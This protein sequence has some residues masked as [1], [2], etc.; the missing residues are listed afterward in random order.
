MNAELPPSAARISRRSALAWTVLLI[1]PNLLLFAW[2]FR[3]TSLW[4]YIR[5]IYSCSD[6]TPF[7]FKL[8]IAFLALGG[9]C[10]LVREK[11]AA[12]FSKIVRIVCS[13]HG[14]AIFIAAFLLLLTAALGTG[15]P[16]SL[17]R[18][19]C[20]AAVLFCA[21]GIGS[22]I[23]ASKLVCL[24]TKAFDSPL[25]RLVLSSALGLGV[26][27]L[28]VFA[29]GS[30]GLMTS[31]F[32][33]LAIAGLC[34]WNFKR[35]RTM[36]GDFS[37]AAKKRLGETNRFALAI[38]IFAALFLIAHLP[39]IWNLPREYDTL[40]YHLAAP[41]EY[42]STGSVHFLSENIYA[43]M[44]E[45][46]EMLYLLPML[47]A[48]GKFD[49]LP[50]AHTILFAAWLLAMGGVYALA[51]RLER[52]LATPSERADSIA[53]LG[54]ALLFT[55]VPMGSQL[56]ADF[57]VEPF[58]ALFHVCAL[59]CACVFLS[60]FKIAQLFKA[61]AINSAN[62]W[63]LCVGIFAGLACGTKY[64]AL[65]FTLLPMAVF[66][67]GCC[68]L[69][70]SIRGAIGAAVRLVLPALI[71]F[72]PWAIRNALAAGDPIFPLGAVLKRRLAGASGIPDK[73]DHY[74]AAHRAGEI[75]WASFRETLHSLMPGLRSRA[76]GDE[77]RLARQLYFLQDDIKFG[78]QL[79]FF[80]LPGLAAIANE[81]TALVAFVFLTDMAFWF[82][83]SLHNERF[84]FP[85]LT[86]LAALCGLGLSRVW[87]VLPLR[88]AAMILCCLALLLFAPLQTLWVWAL[89]SREGVAGADTKTAAEAQ[90]AS[91]LPAYIAAQVVSQ[92][93]DNSRVLFVG[94]AQ[95]FYC[96]RTPAYSVVFNTSPLEEALH[97]TQSADEAVA[98]L[99][100]R[101]ITHIYLNYSE[102][103]RLD[104]S[105][106]LKVSDDG[107]R[108]QLVQWE[109]SAMLNA[110]RET[111]RTYLRRQ[112]FREYAEAWPSGVFAAYLK[113]TPAEYERLEEL[114]ERHTHVKWQFVNPEHPELMELQLRELY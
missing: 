114:F 33:R 90:F 86:A 52:S 79:C 18:A 88:K 40:E 74:E 57:Y 17:L 19:I 48:G 72:A 83:F 6:D 66:L 50:G 55:L 108:W 89:S 92:L 4:K 60:E 54:A 103:L 71:V 1:V 64:L 5:D 113:L 25:E 101:G 14:A 112:Q 53:P 76:I 93:P 37:G 31:G 111:M 10:V 12:L 2:L 78:P 62:S 34:V 107:R 47:L 100:E 98:Y 87:R 44:P 28:A 20:G 109:E 104:T 85:H 29:L 105:Y 42:L 7:V 32:W 26:L 69:G 84:I 102:W 24:E 65:L 27:S 49:G 9:L 8:P 30:A 15:F 73:L 39:L 38:A 41:A 22:R 51:R 35:M 3:G 97:K 56:V 61:H 58:Q 67:P 13:W 82:F 43:T 106:A 68:A 21:A 77:K 36:L 63:A 99:R 81:E 46:G 23:F 94:E 59:L 16:L 11:R 75:S 91:P 95:T 96:E 70:G 110:A 80:S 45:N